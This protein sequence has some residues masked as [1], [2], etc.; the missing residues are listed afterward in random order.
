MRTT[1]VRPRW[2]RIGMFL[3][4][5]LV[6]ACGGAPSAGPD[7]PAPP[8]SAVPSA[9]ASTAPVTPDPSTGLLS[10]EAFKALHQLTPEKAPPARGEMVD[11]AGTKAYLSVPKGKAAPLPAVVVIHEWWG[12]N[13]HIKHW[14]DRLAEDGYAA[15]AVDLYGGKVATN[16]DDA[17]A[18]MKAVDNKKALAT[19]L[20]A[21]EFLEK[22]ARVKA[23]RTASLGW[24][25]GGAW[26][27]Q[28]ALNEPKLDAAV[29]YYGHL[30]T[31]PAEL[32][33]IKAPILGIFGNRDK[34]I[35]P[36]Q[37]NAFD[38]ALGQAGVEHE[39]LRYDA[40]HAFANPSQAARYDEKSAADAWEHVRKFLGQKLKGGA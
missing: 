34:A 6:A 38:K 39:I 1:A 14:A 2:Q 32:K 4:A 5:S 21:H 36:D 9:T 12:L 16:P 11:V 19:V 35:G 3:A 17:M 33:A 8:T 31:E 22:D 24:C 37:V 30:V 18:T 25:F 20:A 15:L 40:D 27:L 26:S 7:A 13:D 28:L 29:I 10:E 23:S